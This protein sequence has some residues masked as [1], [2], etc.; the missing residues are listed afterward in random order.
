MDSQGRKRSVV[1]GH[2]VYKNIWAPFTGEQ[3]SLQAEEDNEHDKYAVAVLKD[4]YVVGH[5]PRAISRLFHFFLQHGGNIICRITG[6]RQFGDGLE[7]PCVYVY[8]GS[9]RIVDKLTRLL[10][11]R[12]Y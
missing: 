4:D 8:S 2:H 9:T 12:P 7:V 3:L 10:N 5:V 11:S 1:K 6:K